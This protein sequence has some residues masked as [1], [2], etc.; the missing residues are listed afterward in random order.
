MTDSKH[1][2]GPWVIDP[3]G[4]ILGNRN[5]PT[6]NG[7]ICGMCEDRRDAE[8]AANARLIAAAPELLAALKEARSWLIDADGGYGTYD[9]EIDAV[10]AVIAKAEGR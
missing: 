3:C 7:L 1:T 10:D 8:G 9:T 2:P 4:D 5:T 6:D